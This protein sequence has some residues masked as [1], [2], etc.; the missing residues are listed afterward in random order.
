M[1]WETASG[2]GHGWRRI[3]ST[4]PGSGPCW[5]RPP[6]LQERQDPIR[7]CLQQGPDGPP[8]TGRGDPLPVAIAADA[9]FHFRYPEAQELLEGCGLQAIP[10]SPLADA[11][12]PGDCR[13]VV[14][15]GGYPELH[16]G[17]LAASRRSLASLAAAA[18][19]GLPVVAECG[20]LLLL[21]QELE[22]DQGIGH[23]MAGLLPFSARRGPLSLG[24]RSALPSRDGLLVRGGEALCGHEFHRWQ[25]VPGRSAAGSWQGPKHCGNLKAGDSLRES[26]DGPHRTF[27]PAGCTST[28][29]DARRFPRGW[30]EPPPAPGRRG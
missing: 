26:K 23:P 10:W 3:T 25:L 12:L 7:W 6:T 11:P 14:L 2:S 27:T 1:T 16:A 29:L 13:A 20:G 9:A 22:D 21:G 24:Y 8:P 28:G 5:R 30:P 15:P 18:R 4:W 17:Q 19:A